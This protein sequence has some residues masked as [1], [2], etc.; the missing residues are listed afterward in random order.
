MVVTQDGFKLIYN[1]DF[2]TF[3]LYDLRND[4]LE[5]HNLFDR[6]PDRAQETRQLLGRFIDVLSVSRPWDADEGRYSRAGAT[7]GDKVEE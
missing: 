5:A 1:R 7:D 2:Y 4:P 6:L 3:E